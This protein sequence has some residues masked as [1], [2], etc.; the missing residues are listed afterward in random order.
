[1]VRVLG[2]GLSHAAETMRYTALAIVLRPGAT[3][4]EIAQAAGR[5]MSRVA[6]L[7]GPM[8]QDMLFLQLRH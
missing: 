8:V 3:E 2:D 7:M 1:M 5:L 6:P 4:L